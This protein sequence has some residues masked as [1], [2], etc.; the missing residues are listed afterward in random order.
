MVFEDITW[1][2]K[3]KQDS[4]APY[5]VFGL[6]INT[7]FTSSSTTFAHHFCNLDFMFLSLGLY[8]SI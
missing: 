2:D 4:W 8:Y 5:N 6:R 7:T 1:F 3:L